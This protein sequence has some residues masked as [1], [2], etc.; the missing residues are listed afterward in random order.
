MKRALLLSCLSYCL[1]LFH[2]FQKKPTPPDEST[3]AGG[4]GSGGGRDQGG[5]NMG[6]DDSAVHGKHLPPS[7]RRQSNVISLKGAVPLLPVIT[8][9]GSDVSE[10]ESHPPQPSSEPA[11]N[12]LPPARKTGDRF[13]YSPSPSHEGEYASIPSSS[14]SIPSRPR[15]AS[16]PQTCSEPPH[17]QNHTASTSIQR[18]KVLTKESMRQY[19]EKA[20]HMQG[21]KGHRDGEG[22]TSRISQSAVLVPWEKE[23]S[24]EEL[25]V[26]GNASGG[27]LQQDQDLLEEIETAYRLGSNLQLSQVHCNSHSAQQLHGKATDES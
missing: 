27:A 14:L 11:P 6:Q 19:Q 16:E 9:E 3:P 10:S 8:A 25:Q 24:K 13:S 22:S 21:S 26:Q 2:L 23:E 17:T 15:T 4:S 12:P 18:R 1:S 7:P 5:W 20:L